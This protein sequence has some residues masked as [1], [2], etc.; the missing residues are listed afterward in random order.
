MPVNSRIPH[1]GKNESPLKNKKGTAD[2]QA[3]SYDLW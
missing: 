1:G 3:D 2:L